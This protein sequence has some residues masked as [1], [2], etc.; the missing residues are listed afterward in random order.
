MDLAFLELLSKP[1][2]YVMLATLAA[3]E[4]VLGIDNIVFITIICGRLPPEQ[5]PN[6]RRIG[7]GVALISRLGLLFTLGWIMGLKANLFSLFGHG[8]SGRDLIL[9]FGGLFLIAKS[10]HEIYHE[11]ETPGHGEG[12]GGQAPASAPPMDGAAAAKAAANSYG[13][14]MVQIIFL[15]LVFSL[16]SVITAVGM[17]PHVSIMATAMII[18]VIVMI[19]F[20]G[21]VGDFVQQHASIRVLALSFLLLIGVLLF[22]EGFGKEVPRGYVY[23]AMGF[24]LFIEVINMR[25]QARARRLWIISRAELSKLDATPAKAPHPLAGYAKP[26]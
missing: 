1:D 21:P 3:L 13:M 4:I 15:D 6:A 18:A 16:D 10:T 17:V 9:A 25:R 11:V 2:T 24:A 20:A 23:F 19:V 22:A 5:Q 12:H 26:E 7:L 14:I 8:F